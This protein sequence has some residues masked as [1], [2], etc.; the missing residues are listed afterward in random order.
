MYNGCKIPIQEVLDLVSSTTPKYLS[1][2]FDGAE[3]NLGILNVRLFAQKGC[4]CVNCDLKGEYFR[5]ER[6]GAGNSIYNDWHLN[7]YGTDQL[8]REMMITKDHIH[9]RSKGGSDDISN[10]Q[11]MC[12]TCNTNKKSMSMEEFQNKQNGIRMDYVANSLHYFDKIK[13][14]MMERY[15]L[16]IDKKSFELMNR[17]AHNARVIKNLG[18]N[19]SIKDVSVLGQNVKV[20]YCGTKKCILSAMENKPDEW[21]YTDMIP[22]FA[23]FD[24][25]RAKVIYNHV[26]DTARLQ[27]KELNTNADTAKYFQQCDFPPVMFMLW[28]EPNNSSKISAAVWNQVQR[29]FKALALD[30]NLQSQMELNHTDVTTD[31]DI[32]NE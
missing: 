6:T 30:D 13:M 23:K 1:G 4:D 25:E 10:L 17:N 3:V 21:F 14:R 24:Q 11:P 16:D 5:V 26:L 8:G 7:L 12:L 18:N 32:K 9:A 19:K 15:L 22:S 31:T 20:L 2:V 29:V 28:K 27:M